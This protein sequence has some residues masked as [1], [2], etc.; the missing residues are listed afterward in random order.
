MKNF[1]IGIGLHLGASAVAIIVAA[2]IL[3]GFR[4]HFFGF[5]TAVVVFTVAQGLLAGLISK[6]TQKHAPSI[7]G[8][9]ALIST[10]LALVLANLFGGGTVIHGFFT[11]ILATVIVWAVTAAGALVR[12]KIMAK[13]VRK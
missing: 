4:L 11:W 10:F 5:I 8:A 7:A 12:P 1:L 2:L 13:A 6:L 3:P 9:A